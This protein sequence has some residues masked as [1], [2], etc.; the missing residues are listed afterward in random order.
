MKRKEFQSILRSEPN[1]DLKI[2]TITTFEFTQK[3]NDIPMFS[4]LV[5]LA[6]LGT[7]TAPS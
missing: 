5:T 6:S 2:A 4:D 1:T 7:Q 3:G